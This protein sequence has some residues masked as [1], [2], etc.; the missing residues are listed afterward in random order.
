MSVTN[1]YHKSREHSI[2]L[3][4][5]STENN[6]SW[7][8]IA[9]NDGEVFDVVLNNVA[10]YTI[11]GN[12]ITIPFNLNAGQSYLV[13]I[14]KINNGF[15]ASI[16]LRTRRSKNKFSE[17]AVPDF[18]FYDGRYSFALTDNQKIIKYDND[19]FIP[20]NFSDFNTTITSPKVSTYTLP[21]NNSILRT[22]KFV[23]IEAVEYLLI[24]GAVNW[25]G[26]STPISS[27]GFEAI[28]FRISDN[29]FWSI[30]R[31]TQNQWTFYQK[32]VRANS[33]YGCTYNYI[34][35]V[36]FYT[37]HSGSDGIKINLLT[38][39][40]EFLEGTI[41]DNFSYRLTKQGCGFNPVENIYAARSVVFNEVR[42]LG[43]VETDSFDTAPIFDRK[44]LKWV[45]STSQVNIYNF[46]DTFGTLNSSISLTNLNS[47]NVSPL[48][49]EQKFICH[50]GGGSGQKMFAILDLDT[51]TG[52]VHTIADTTTGITFNGGC[53]SNKNNI[54]LAT[55]INDIYVNVGAKE[56]NGNEI[57]LINP[58]NSSSPAYG[59]YI[60]IEGNIVSLVSNQYI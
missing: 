39:D 20:S 33:G 11:D 38:G 26:G 49:I 37:T 48:Y 19:L 32:D 50:L 17:L 42:N 4:F 46:Y 16:S 35:N 3:N 27:R 53:A 55:M 52:F 51:M 41:L 60:E 7:V 5:P 2:T 30:D 54:F 57:I 28:L 58:A 1:V 59:R 25:L 21:A 24:I 13:E 12:L 43:V 36:V 31:S 8:F 44:T 10:S 29:T 34:D 18:G 22:I 15:E 23:T 47:R 40:F 45:K 56:T 6:L 14:L 9:E